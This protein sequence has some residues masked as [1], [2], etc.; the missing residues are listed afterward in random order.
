MV[1]FKLEPGRKQLHYKQSNKPRISAKRSWHL[2]SEKLLCLGDQWYRMVSNGIMMVSY[3]GDPR[4]TSI[5]S[6]SSHR[7]VV[8]RR[9]VPGAASPC[10]QATQIG[11]APRRRSFH[12]Q[13]TELQK[14]CKTSQKKLLIE[15]GTWKNTSILQDRKIAAQTLHKTRMTWKASSILL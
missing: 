5:S 6:T 11:S 3:H 7:H 10:D 14:I 2:S 15:T 12:L 13:T 9:A 4:H 1:P 8:P